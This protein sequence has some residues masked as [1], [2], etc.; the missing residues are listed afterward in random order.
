MPRTAAPTP[1]G[2]RRR[3]PGS[4]S[5]PGLRLPNIPSVQ[6]KRH[7]STRG[8][9]RRAGLC[10]CRSYVH[11]G[12]APVPAP[13]DNHIRPGHGHL[14]ASRRGASTNHRE[15][16][17]A[18]GMMIGRAPSSGLSHRHEHVRRAVTATHERSRQGHRDPRPAHQITVLARQLGAD[19]ELRFAPEDR[20]HL[21]AP[22]TSLPREVLRRLR[23]LIQPDIV[24]RGHGDLT[25]T[26]S[27]PYL[28][29]EAAW[30]PTHR[31]V[32]PRSRP[33]SGSG[34]PRLGLPAGPR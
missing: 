3:S 14:E 25:K 7:V 15:R 11:P 17:N 32:H 9:R 22:L 28:S 12:H 18:Y 16:A 2:V 30:P 31:P 20:A 23:L 33:T 24:L 29:A 13:A 6:V 26:A 21:A 34:E 1:R 8:G 4:S 27:Y 5:R 19:T 10:A